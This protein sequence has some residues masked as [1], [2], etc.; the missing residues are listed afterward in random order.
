MRPQSGVTLIEMLIVVMIIA[1]IA[2]ITFPAL[3][4]GLASVRLNS[5]SGSAA[6]F[7]TA[8]MNRVERRETAAAVVIAPKEDELEVF[9]AASG[10]KPERTLRMP[11]GIFIEGEEPR[12]FLLQPGGAFPRVTLVLRN[13]KGARRSVRIDP[14]TGVP[15]IRRVEAEK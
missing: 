7:L 5:A 3:A 14:A 4:A 10:E 2:G 15:D 8:A 1:L 6:S 11:Q 13:E 9:T 12:R